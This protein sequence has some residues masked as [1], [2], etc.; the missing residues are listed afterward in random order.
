MDPSFVSL[1]PGNRPTDTS[2]WVNTNA[3]CT[4]RILTFGTNC[5]GMK[6]DGDLHGG[7]NKSVVANDFTQVISGGIGMWI[8]HGG[9]TNL[10][11]CLLILS[12]GYPSKQAGKSLL[13]VTTPR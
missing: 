3:S 1:D 6:V 9:L 5:V 4:K 7:G 8:T 12:I 11:P 2:V 10:L 13:T